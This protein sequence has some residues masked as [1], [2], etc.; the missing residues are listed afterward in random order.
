MLLVSCI[1]AYVIAKLKAQ[2]FV[3]GRGSTLNPSGPPKYDPSIGPMIP[4]MA[5]PSDCEENPNAGSAPYSAVH[6]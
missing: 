5:F 3:I 6:G 4:I 2:Q 1:R